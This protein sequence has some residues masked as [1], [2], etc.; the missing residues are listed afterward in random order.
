[1]PPLRQEGTSTPMLSKI[2]TVC[3]HWELFVLGVGRLLHGARKKQGSGCRSASS[4][5][6]EA[7]CGASCIQ[8]LE[9]FQESNH[10][11]GIVEIATAD[12]VDGNGQ[13]SHSKNATDKI[14]GAGFDD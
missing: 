7:A 11:A 6:R 13:V 1:M 2:H 8:E 12:H 14:D 3:W 5:I 4:R 9:R 10:R